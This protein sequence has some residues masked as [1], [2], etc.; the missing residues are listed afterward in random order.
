MPLDQGEDHEELRVRPSEPVVSRNAHGQSLDDARQAFR[1]EWEAKIREK[2]EQADRGRRLVNWWH[3]ATLR[4]LYG[5]AWTSFLLGMLLVLL[6]R[7]SEWLTVGILAFFLIIPFV[8][9]G[10]LTEYYW[11]KRAQRLEHEAQK[12]ELS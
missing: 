6:T 4:T 2:W 12:L 3:T 8:F 9:A 11:K 5:G 1:A 10:S 7:R